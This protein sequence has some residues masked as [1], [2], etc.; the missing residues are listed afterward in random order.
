MKKL[1]KLVLSQITDEKGMFILIIFEM[2]IAIVTFNIAFSGLY[3]LWL[4]DAIYNQMNLSQAVAFTLTDYDEN[5]IS[6]T[7]E[8]LK[9]DSKFTVLGETQIGLNSSEAYIVPL[10]EDFIKNIKQPNIKG[11][12]FKKVDRETLSVVV[13]D[14]MTDK[15][16]IG[17]TYSII[18]N[19]NKFNIYISG[20]LDN[21]YMFLPPSGA[22]DIIQKNENLILVDN[23]D[24]IISK[25]VS[26][27][28]VVTAY[29]NCD[30]DDGVNILNNYDKINDVVSVSSAKANDAQIKL[31]ENS[32]PI[33]LTVAVV[34]MCIAGFASC[35]VLSL[36]QK[37]KQFAVFFLT[38][39]TRQKCILIQLTKDIITVAIPMIISFILLFIFKSYGLEKAFC[40]VGLMISAII[41]V[42][43]FFVTSFSGLL[44]LSKKEPIEI[45]RQW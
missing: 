10:S 22:S 34:F 27:N 25:D 1:F 16:E 18:I 9:K 32:I 39:S 20:A 29:I 26:K 4:K 19:K 40:G 36:V 45:I 42:V 6:K 8:K 35:N 12:W 23:S 11:E 7:Y 15:Y 28:V 43:I 30:I 31:Q 17:N 13:S 37:E 2:I 5:N 44:K 41:C 33:I 24:S 21:D 14:S 3:D 38:G